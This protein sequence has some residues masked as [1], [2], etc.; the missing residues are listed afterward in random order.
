[1]MNCGMKRYANVFEW[2]NHSHQPPEAQ[3]PFLAAATASLVS[4]ASIYWLDGHEVSSLRIWWAEGL[5][6]AFVPT[7]LAFIILYRSAWH[8]DMTRTPRTFLVAVL[9]CLIFPGALI[10]A[11]ISLFVAI[12]VYTCYCDGFTRF[13]Y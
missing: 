8:Q 11:G 12:L 13:H 2:L 10:A 1:M 5:I 4:F 6:Y 3:S 7:L 9:S